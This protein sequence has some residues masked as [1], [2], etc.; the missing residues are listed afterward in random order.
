MNKKFIRI[1]SLVLSVMML[2]SCAV[3][4]SAEGEGTDAPAVTEKITV[5]VRVE[6]LLKQL[7]K[8]NVVIDKSSTVKAVI[9]AAAVNVVYELDSTTDIYAVKEEVEGTYSEWQYAVDGVIKTDAIDTVRL[10][11]NCEI[12]LYNASPDA[13]FPAINADELVTTGVI[14][15][16]GTDK[17]GAVAPIKDLKVEW[18]TKTGE[19]VFTTDNA[20]KIYLLEDEFTKGKHDI[21]ISKLNDYNVPAVVRLDKNTEIDV[22]EFEGGDQTEKTLFEQVYDFLY[23]IL[24]GVIDVWTFY[25]KAIIGLFG[26]GGEQ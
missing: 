22:P 21:E 24:K 9:D 17:N 10:E 2:F 20:G 16:T 7:A 6:G 19:K 3:V 18:E 25:F 1:L 26:V 12:V 13:V 23:D 15:F 14:L 4:A 11:N 8:K 5:T